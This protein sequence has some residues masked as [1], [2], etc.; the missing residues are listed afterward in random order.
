MSKK[1][2]LVHWDESEANELAAK[3]DP[4]KWEVEYEFEDGARAVSAIKA[5][6]PDVVV[7][8]LT[9]LPSHGAETAHAI[10]HLKATKHLPIIF[11]GGKPDGL[12][13]VKAKV[14]DAVFVQESQLES[15]LAAI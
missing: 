5:K 9:K 6:L 4:E 13:K 11:V 2:Y 1:L 12:E 10:R 7:I 14:P 3:Y 8:Y 15:A